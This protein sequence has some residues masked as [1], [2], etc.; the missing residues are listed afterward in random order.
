[1]EMGLFIN[2]IIEIGGGRGRGGGKP[3]VDTKIT[4]GGQGVWTKMKSNGEEKKSSSAI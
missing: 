4:E 3:K 2:Y 1:M